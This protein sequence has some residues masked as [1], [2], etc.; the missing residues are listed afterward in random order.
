MVEQCPQ[1][2]SQPEEEEED[3]LVFLGDDWRGIPLEVAAVDLGND[4][5]LIIHAMRC[6]SKYAATYQQVTGRPL[7]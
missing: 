5:L 1:P 6:R 7:H 3:L 2:L 4:S